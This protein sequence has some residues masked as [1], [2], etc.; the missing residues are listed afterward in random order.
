M[1]LKVQRAK[2]FLTYNACGFDRASSI[3]VA[4]YQ[5]F[6]KI[7]RDVDIAMVNDFL[8]HKALGR[9]FEVIKQLTHI[10]G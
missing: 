10:K 1:D 9:Y 6:S 3:E 5:R 2:S 8:R 4:K 7:S